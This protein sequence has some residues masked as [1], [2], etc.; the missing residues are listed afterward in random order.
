ME[1][2]NSMTVLK[3]REKLGEC[4]VHGE[5]AGGCF[6]LFRISCVDCEFLVIILKKVMMITVM[7]NFGILAA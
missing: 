1:K 5:L 6:Y 7:P 4:N 2:K 3:C